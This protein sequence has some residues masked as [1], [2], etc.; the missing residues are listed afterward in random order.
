MMRLSCRNVWRPR[1]K[2]IKSSPKQSMKDTVAHQQ[3]LLLA[4]D[5]LDK[6]RAGFCTDAILCI[7]RN[8]II[9]INQEQD[10]GLKC[11]IYT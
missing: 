2:V 7:L 6:E 10:I 11:W 3:Q 1:S 8:S 4:H 5:H 9:N